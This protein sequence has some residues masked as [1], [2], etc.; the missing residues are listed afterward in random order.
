M[1]KVIIILLIALPIGAMGMS[2]FKKDD[3]FRFEDYESAEEVKVEL[4][5]MHPVG[6]SVE[7]LIAD[8]ERAGSDVNCYVAGAVYKYSDKEKKMV[9][10]KKYPS[11][12]DF[13][14]S[15]TKMYSLLKATNLNWNVMIKI[16]KN[17]KNIKSIDVLRNIEQIK[18]ATDRIV[19]KQ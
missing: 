8:L 17:S 10:E 12:Y 3:G 19:N 11:D 18:F 13:I 16:D 4:L 14:C 2:I 9:I 15:Y 7:G 6:D 5:K 1:K